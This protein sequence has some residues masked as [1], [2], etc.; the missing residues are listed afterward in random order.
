LLV[1]F[2][3]LLLALLAF[4]A[5]YLVPLLL[6]LTV[7]PPPSGYV[8]VCQ[9]NKAAGSPKSLRNAGLAGRS[10][11]VTIGSRGHIRVS[12]LKS[13]EFRVERRGKEV[14]VVDAASD[15]VKCTVRQLPSQVNTSDV[16]TVLRFSTDPAQLRCGG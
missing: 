7:S 8:L 6:A 10:S 12:K 15:Q 9:G 5:L 11:K 3:L 16:S 14:I 4:L 2:G 13:V 1:V